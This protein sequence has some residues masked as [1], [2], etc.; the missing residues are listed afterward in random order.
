M[1]WIADSHAVLGGFLCFLTA[2]VAVT[3]CYMESLIVAIP[4]TLILGIY[5]LMIL[6]YGSMSCRERQSL[7][8][9]IEDYV[10]GTE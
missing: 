6:I 4:L 3:A 7:K 2:V 5:V 8:W 9:S 10:N 1:I